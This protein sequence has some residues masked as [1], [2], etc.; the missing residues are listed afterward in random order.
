MKYL[1]YLLAI[2][3]LVGLNL[4]L[5]SNLQLQGQI[6]NLLLLFTLCAALEK[7]N[8]DFFFIAFV[9]GLFL[10]FYSA[11]FFG[12]FT[13]SLVLVAYLLH[14]LAITL[15]VLELDWKSFSLLLFASMVLLDLF[16][17]FYGF[18]AYKFNFSAGF[19]P[20]QSFTK[21]F[22]ASYVYNLVFLFPS[23]VFYN[24]ILKLIDNLSVRR[25][26]VVR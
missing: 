25:R 8:Y 9:S 2:I 15:A 13:L 11:S 4:G 14:S 24:F 26:G 12:S 18:A 23:L 22:F 5:F 20:F 1:I 21:T 7:K 10:D 19:I 3:V 6:P 16:S 17:W